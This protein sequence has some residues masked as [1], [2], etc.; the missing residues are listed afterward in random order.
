MSFNRGKIPVVPGLSKIGGVVGLAALGLGINS[1]LF[2]G[3][4]NAPADALRHP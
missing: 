1:S 3:N 2:N 4:S